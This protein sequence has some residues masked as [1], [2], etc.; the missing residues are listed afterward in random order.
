MVTRVD[1]QPLAKKKPRTLGKELI[2]PYPHFVNIK[3]VLCS[4]HGE[5]VTA[6]WT[7]GRQSAAV[8]GCL[9]VGYFATLY[10]LLLL[11]IFVSVLY[12]QYAGNSSWKCDICCNT[13]WLLGLH[14]HRHTQYCCHVVLEDSAQSAVYKCIRVSSK[15]IAA[16]YFW[17][18]N[19]ISVFRK[20]PYHWFP[21]LVVPRPGSGRGRWRWAPLSVFFSYLRLKWLLPDIMKLASLH[22]AHSSHWEFTNSALVIK[23]VI[24]LYCYY[25]T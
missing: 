19:H 13:G 7:H 8:I 22:Q 21:K 12:F 10:R 6:K 1:L 2:R 3:W 9:I 24:L 15:Q 20:V 16:I 17:K 25:L 18:T 4:S 11:F 5:D 23:C 14:V